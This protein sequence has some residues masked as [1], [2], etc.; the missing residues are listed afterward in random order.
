VTIARA[1]TGKRKVLVARGSYHG[2]VPWCSPSTVG[3]TTEDRAHLIQ[4]DY[5]NVASLEAAVAEAG[6][7]LAAILLTTFRHDIQRDQELPEQA[8]LAAARKACDRTGAALIQDDV[9]AGFRLD[10]RGSW[11]PYGI[12][13][14]LAAYSKSIANGWPLACIAGNTRMLGGAAKIFT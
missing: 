8:F 9:R 14:D 4:F 3:V 10:V 1:A 6:D 13:P 2:A 12:K 7:D 11:A 5:N